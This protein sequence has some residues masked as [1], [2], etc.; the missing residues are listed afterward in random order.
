MNTFKLATLAVLAACSASGAQAQV[1]D[2]QVLAHALGQCFV[3]KTTGADRIVVMRWMVGALASA[4]QTADMVRVD[5][6]RKIE[7]DKGMAALFTRLIAVDCVE[8][9]R[10]I[11]KSKNHEGIEAAG[12]SLGDIALKEL[13]TNPDAAKAMETFT[14]YLRQSDFAAVLK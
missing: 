11:F 8:Q 2:D 5:P 1:Q 6:A 9:A 13:M 3:D 10:P 7:V 14:A 4:P 12:G